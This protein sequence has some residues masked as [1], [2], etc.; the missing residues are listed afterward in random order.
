[1]P[2]AVQF[3]KFAKREN[4][5]A[6]PDLSGGL[7]LDC[8]LKEETSLNNPTFLIEFTHP[9]QGGPD[10]NSWPD[11]NYCY[12]VPWGKYFFVSDWTNEGLL[13]RA[14]C[15]IDVLATYRAEILAS[16]Q[17]VSYSSVVG[18][19][20]LPDTRIPVL[21]STQVK[22]SSATAPFFIDGGWYIL[23]CIGKKGSALYALSGPQL[24]K[25][26][27]ALA[28]STDDFQTEVGTRVSTYFSGGAP[29]TAEEALYALAQVSTQNDI[30]GHAYS[31]APSCLRS[32]IFVPLAL[33]GVNAETIWLGNFDTG[34]SGVIIDGAPIAGS[35]SVGIPWTFSDWRRGY[36]EQVYL[37]L[38]LVGMVAI[39]GD[40]LTH[41]D[42]LTVEYSYTL[43]DGTIAYRVNAGGEIIGTYG[44][45]CAINY[46]LG[47]NQQA[48]A[49]Q[50]MNAVMQGVTQ[51]VAA[52]I[53]G[54]IGGVIMGIAATGYNA[55][56]VALTS[57]PSSV[58]GIGGGAGGGLSRDITCYTVAHN[59]VIEPEAM[60]ATMGRPTM[61]PVQ[62][63]SCSGYCQCANAHVSAVA[64]LEEL[65]AITTLLNTGFYIE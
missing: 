16:T 19:A 24:W 9:T 61:K 64:S 13:W 43:T 4:S 34:V 15:N 7:V 23:S 51:T 45:S 40:N 54:N 63:S 31:T 46:P 49:G 41:T 42:S 11:Y 56:D 26:I 44:G 35:V 47:I 62:L 21:R 2:F 52:G 36:C 48:S 50:V 14:H 38:P 1:M 53:S 3:F 55:L 39:S 59:T 22:S 5:T 12:V 33:T 28:G 32:C 57:H 58:G 8:V 10:A 29:Q 17:F 27:S 60:T 30:L 37:Y 65:S 18:D 20:W 25:L 6:R